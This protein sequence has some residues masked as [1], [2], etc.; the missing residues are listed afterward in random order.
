MWTMIAN[1]FNAIHCCQFTTSIAAISSPRL[2]SEPDAYSAKPITLLLGRRK[3]RLDAELRT[4]VLQDGS[5]I[6][7]DKCLLAS[8]GAPRDFYV[9]DNNQIPFS[10]RENIN[11]LTKL[12]HFVDLDASGNEDIEHL[13]VVGG[14][15]LG[16]EMACSVMTTY[17][18]PDIIVGSTP[19]NTLRIILRSIHL[20]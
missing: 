14:G 2:E 11:T 12:Q 18:I 17:V 20:A 5:K 6:S 8:A 1:F 19:H 10:L 13:T 7:Y 16:T 15:F 9:L 4:V 3:L